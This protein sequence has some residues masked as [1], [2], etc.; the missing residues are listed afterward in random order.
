MPVMDTFSAKK[1]N[2]KVCFDVFVRE[3]GNAKK[4]LS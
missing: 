3:D 4:I 2:Q 1:S